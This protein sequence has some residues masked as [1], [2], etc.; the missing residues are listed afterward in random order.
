[1]PPPLAAI[2][3]G[4]EGGHSQ[5]DSLEAMAVESAS[6]GSGSTPNKRREVAGSAKVGAALQVMTEQ[7]REQEVETGIQSVVALL[8]KDPLLI[9]PV[10]AFISSGANL[11]DPDRF[12]RGVRK[13][14][15]V[16]WRDQLR[17]LRE[18]IGFDKAFLTALPSS[19]EEVPRLFYYA[20]GLKQSFPVSEASRRLLYQWM[21]NQYT[22]MGRP[23]D[24]LVRKGFQSLDW[25]TS[26]CA[27]RIIDSSGWVESIKHEKSGVIK[28][29]P[30]RFQTKELNINWVLT[31]N[32]SMEEAVLTGI[33]DG[34]ESRIP[35]IKLFPDVAVL[36]AVPS[37][38][39]C[40]E[41]Q[42]ASSVQVPMGAT[43]TAANL[44]ALTK[45][46]CKHETI[47]KQNVQKKPDDKSE[48]ISQQNAQTK[49]DDKPETISQQKAPNDKSE[50]MSQQQEPE[51]NSAM[52]AP[53]GDGCPSGDEGGGDA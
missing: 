49:P 53:P 20:C 42:S 4:Q 45:E 2:L 44:T 50:T 12:P 18:V 39:L 16:P 15:S 30:I 35:I 29:L 26:I 11:G 17:G 37:I 7:L 6:T 38:A 21:G 27:Y 28:K 5:S 52:E 43:L 10:K 13:L 24:E 1:M 19:K 14:S 40:D 22:H 33:K 32:Y 36:T 9:L 34:M 8:R 31:D 47:S 46:E 51:G 48:M 25:N 23:L 3:A 41:R